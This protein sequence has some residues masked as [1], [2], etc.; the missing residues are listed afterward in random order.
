MP[1]MDLFQLLRK[2]SAAGNTTP[3]IVLTGFRSND[4]G[5][6]VVRELK[7]F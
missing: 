2:L 1:R 4:K 5:S 6:T 7:A 3:A